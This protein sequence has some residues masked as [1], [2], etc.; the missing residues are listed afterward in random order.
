LTQ[1]RG[2]EWE[3]LEPDN[4]HRWLV[5]PQTKEFE[6]Y[7][8]LG[9]K[10]AK[11]A[12]WGE[13]ET[14]FKTYSN[15]VKTSKNAFV[16]DFDEEA[17]EQRMRGMIDLYNQEVNRWANRS[18]RNASIQE[19]LIDDDTRIKWTR[20]LR[21]RVKQGKLA[22]FDRANIVDAYFRPFAK[23]KLYYDELL[24][25]RP[26]PFSAA[27]PTQNSKEENCI[28]WVKEGSGWPFFALAVN[29]HSELLPQSGS[30]CFP[31]YVYDEDGTNR[32]EN[33][34]DWALAQFREHYSDA[35]ISKWD[36]FYYIYGVLHHPRY[37]ERYADNLD[38]NL[39]HIPFAPSFHAF[40]E[41]GEKLADLHV[42]YED[43]EPYPLDENESGQL[44]WRVEK[45]QWRQNKTALK[46]NDFLTLEGIPEKAHRYEV[47]NR[48]ALEWLRN[49]YRVRTY[50]RYD[51]THDPND[52]NDKWYIVDLIKRVTRV[53]VETVEIVEAL[54]D[55]GLP[56]D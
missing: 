10:D 23:K 6:S 42:G 52:P 41:A 49:Q 53:S 5:D 31:F 30:Q 29:Q 36:I 51:I 48:T 7:V 47:G 19:F 26:G 27:L 55:L 56:T 54:P 22:E 4:E 2:I 40:A 14:I 18:N 45:M 9:S 38:R 34:T 33:I 15:G 11:K 32:R 13:A 28:L 35:S 46:Y 12:E 17:L 8:A 50:N 3:E 25:N 20:E 16:Y 37:R 43:V 39:P 21:R 24:L 1:P 44:E